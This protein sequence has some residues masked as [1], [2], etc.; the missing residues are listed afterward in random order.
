MHLAHGQPPP[1][2]TTDSALRMVL[3]V[4][5][6]HDP[7]VEEGATAQRLVGLG[8]R[9]GNAPLLR[10]GR[11]V[12]KPRA[13]ALEEMGVGRGERGGERG[14]PARS[15]QSRRSF[16]KL[17]FSSDGGSESRARVEELPMC[18]RAPGPSAVCTDA[19][20]TMGRASAPVA[21]RG[22]A[23]STID[24]SEGVLTIL[25]RRP[26]RAPFDAV[27]RK[28]PLDGRSTTASSCA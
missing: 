10:A 16:L 8:S 2:R 25:C 19:W 20:R 12:R 21:A 6:L 14:R 4:H 7:G 17:T 26:G 1:C 23:S 22:S 27:P 11:G 5:A 3:F 9:R 28:P 13:E 24:P 18:G 15:L